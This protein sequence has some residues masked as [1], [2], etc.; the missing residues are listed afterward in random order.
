MNWVLKLATRATAEPQPFCL[1]TE[2]TILVSLRG[3]GKKVL[4]SILPS[5]RAGA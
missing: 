4:L 3:R 5:S 1:F 2:N